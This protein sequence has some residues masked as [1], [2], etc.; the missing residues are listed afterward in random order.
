M[1]ETTTDDAPRTSD[2]GPEHGYGAPPSPRTGLL[3]ALG[4]AWL[5]AVLLVARA[6]IMV[7][8][9]LAL[10]TAA[11]ALP[12]VIATSVLAGAVSGL[13]AVG[14][15]TA[16]R[17]EWTA[18]LALRA[19]LA[20]LAGL[21]A[22][23]LGSMVILVNSG[24][25]PSVT[26]LVAAVCTAGGVG[27]AL[28]AVRPASVG[29]A[30]LTA[31]L[32]VLVIG[33]AL[34]LF[35]DPLLTVFGA[36][37]STPSRLSAAGWFALTEALVSGV[38]AGLVAFWCLRRAHRRDAGRW[39]GPAG[40]A[41]RRPALGWPAYLAAGAT[42]GVV[43]LLAEAVTRLGGARLLEL[44]G[45]VSELDRTA[46]R[47]AGSARLNYA[48]VVLFLGAILAMIAFGRTLP[49]PAGEPPAEPAA[50]ELATAR[51]DGG[52]AAPAE[53]GKAQA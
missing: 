33:F 15:L 18:R 19:A 38:T 10:I 37:E 2:T 48:L 40:S 49:G 25:Y 22:A 17:P 7:N 5:A 27:G 13:T 3:L 9:E 36:G 52:D 42:T 28:G 23:G 46:L 45:S 32:A 8:G 34:R 35:K 12:T 26:V 47:L 29:A 24:A 53:P 51:P 11:I 6:S 1:T 31:A 41:A 43:L 30:G 39:A 4:V 16:R 14:A 21:L 20:V 50:A 44:A